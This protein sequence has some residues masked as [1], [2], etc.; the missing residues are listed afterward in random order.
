VEGLGFIQDRSRV[1]QLRL[2]CG[3][4]RCQATAFS[5]GWNFRA[6]ELSLGSDL[7]RRFAR[8]GAAQMGVTIE[9]LL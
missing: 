8:S 7:I 5:F 9:L 6:R 4:I 2:G 1:T 3:C